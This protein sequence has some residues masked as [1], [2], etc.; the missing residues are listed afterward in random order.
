MFGLS[1]ARVPQT[2][3]DSI[4]LDVNAASTFDQIVFSKVSLY[5][6]V[7]NHQ[8]LMATNQMLDS[9]LE[10][11]KSKPGLKI[12]GIS[13]E[14]PI[15]FLELTDWDLLTGETDDDEIRKIQKKIERRNLPVRLFRISPKTAVEGKLSPKCIKIFEDK[16]KKEELRVLIC[17]DLGIATAGLDS[18]SIGLPYSIKRN[19]LVDP[20][21]KHFDK[22]IVTF[23][24]VFPL[25]W[26]DSYDTLKWVGY[27]FGAPKF[28]NRDSYNKIKG[29]LE[30]YL[31]MSFNE[32]SIPKFYPEVQYG[33]STK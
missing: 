32:K 17:R 28:A 1:V 11:M 7:Y 4:V 27:V 10:R 13:L 29:V 21:C 14:N 12:K 18:I 15:N 19:E 25:L 22:T 30:Q 8:K 6:N 2:G 33:T 9:I 5:I 26:V 24:E 3:K 31:A 20:Y 16:H 23:N